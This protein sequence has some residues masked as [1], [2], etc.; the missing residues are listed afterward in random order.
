LHIRKEVT[1]EIKG[2]SAALH[3]MTIFFVNPAWHAC[4]TLDKLEV[5]HFSD[6]TI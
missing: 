2:I 5:P 1:N 4:H 3:S 6:L